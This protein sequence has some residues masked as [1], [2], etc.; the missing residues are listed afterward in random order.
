[1]SNQL[2][3]GFSVRLEP[4]HVFVFLWS[5]VFPLENGFPS[6]YFYLSHPCTHFYLQLTYIS[7]YPVIFTISPEN[8]LMV[9]FKDQISVAVSSLPHQDNYHLLRE[10]FLDGHNWVS[11]SCITSHS[12]SPL[13]NLTTY[14]IF[15]FV[16]LLNS[17]LISPWTLISLNYGDGWWDKESSRSFLSNNKLNHI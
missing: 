5:R 13:L 8:S 14:V 10:I 3:A 1:M 4:L 16:L 12:L 15:V 9:V 17:S 2:V 6:F 11:A 7:C